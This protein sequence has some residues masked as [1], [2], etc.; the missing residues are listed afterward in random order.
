MSKNVIDIGSYV[1]DYCKINKICLPKSL[2]SYCAGNSIKTIE[3]AG[4]IAEWDIVQKGNY[5]MGGV[6]INCSNGTV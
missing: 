2:R 6:T 4:T 1:F 5:Y 3:Y